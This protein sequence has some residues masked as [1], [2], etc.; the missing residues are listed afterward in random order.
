MTGGA[1]CSGTRSQLRFTLTPEVGNVEVWA[2]PNGS[3]PLV[4]TTGLT[5]PLLSALHSRGGRDAGQ[6]SM[7]SSG[8]W[9]CSPRRSRRKEQAHP[10]TGAAA[11]VRQRQRTGDIVQQPVPGTSKRPAPPRPAPRAYRRRG[12]EHQ[13]CDWLGR[14]ETLP[15]LRSLQ[16]PAAGLPDKRDT[17]RV[18]SRIIR[19]DARH[20]SH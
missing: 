5:S 4:G 15:T 13:G 19:S 18:H 17:R 14:P 10:G 8:E 11:G 6:V 20:H 9:R 1:R 12:P 16:D 3:K 2:I 7:G